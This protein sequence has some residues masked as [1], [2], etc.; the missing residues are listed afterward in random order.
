M[1]YFKFGTSI[2]DPRIYQPLKMY[3]QSLDPIEETRIIH[4][5]RK[6]NKTLH[7][8]M[9][10]K[11]VNFFSMLDFSDFVKIEMYINGTKNPT[12][13]AIGPALKIFRINLNNVEQWSRSQWLM[14][15]T[16]VSYKHYVKKSES[17]IIKKGLDICFYEGPQKFERNRTLMNYIL[18]FNSGKP[19]RA[20]DFHNF[21]KKHFSTETL[22][23]IGF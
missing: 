23:C 8:V 12:W 19:L 1:P 3:L 21:M 9:S 13:N 2:E 6:T 5:L 15:L 10:S 22:K 16:F 18:I 7:T 4:P 14:Y 20:I 17:N 11:K